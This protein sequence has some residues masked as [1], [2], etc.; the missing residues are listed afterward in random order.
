[1]E[2]K[3]ELNPELLEKVAGGSFGYSMEDIVKLYVMQCQEK[4][5]TEEQAI[6]YIKSLLSQ[7]FDP[8]A[9]EAM[10]LSIW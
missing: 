8:S 9:V 2:K 3:P 5:M 4:E 1:M 6:A 10:I 7:L